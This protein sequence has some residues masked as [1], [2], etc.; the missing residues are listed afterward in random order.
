LFLNT[1]LVNGL[2]M[3][4][5][6]PLAVLMLGPLGFAPWQYGLAFAVPCLGGLLGSRL[7]RPLAARH[8]RRRVLLA[9]GV[10]RAC[11]PIGLALVR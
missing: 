7:A 1:V 11:W 9:S 8:G 2:I 6:P 5:A 4:Q 3:A 10:L